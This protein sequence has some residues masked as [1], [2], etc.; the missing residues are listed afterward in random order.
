[1]LFFLWCGLRG[2]VSDGDTG[3]C[4]EDEECVDEDGLGGVGVEFVDECDADDDGYECEGEVD[5]E[6]GG[7]SVDR[8]IG[9][10]VFVVHGF[11][12]SHS[13]C[14]GFFCCL[15]E[16]VGCVESVEAEDGEDVFVILESV[17]ACVVR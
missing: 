13:F 4:A 14:E 17:E 7:S 6:R 1:M 16:V 2:A 5:E 8:L 12:F 9:L 10:G 11:M 3:E 15:F